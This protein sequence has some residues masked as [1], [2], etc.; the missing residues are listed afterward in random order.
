MTAGCEQLGNFDAGHTSTP[1]VEFFLLLPSSPAVITQGVT[2]AAE[3]GSMSSNCT[4]GRVIAGVRLA[5]G[6]KTPASF[7]LL[8]LGELESLARFLLAVFF[9]LDHAGVARHQTR[10][11]EKRTVFTARLGEA[12]GSFPM[13]LVGADVRRL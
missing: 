13:N 11:A 3:S 4:G 9:P 1:Y 8:S 6:Q 10:S 12:S 7:L 2:L 5:G